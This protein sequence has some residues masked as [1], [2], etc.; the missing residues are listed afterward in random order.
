VLESFQV[1]AVVAVAVVGMLK[2]KERVADGM[3]LVILVGLEEVWMF[4]FDVVETMLL[5]W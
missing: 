5:G 2:W 4:H 1:V 3:G